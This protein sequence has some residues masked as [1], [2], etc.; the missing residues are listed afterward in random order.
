MASEG[1]YNGG[2]FER[3]LEVLGRIDWAALPDA[4]AGYLRSP[5]ERVR[6]R[7]AELLGARGDVPAMDLVARTMDERADDAL[8][9]GAL[10]GAA[11]A[12][13]LGRATAMFRAALFDRVARDL[14]DP[15]PRMLRYPVMCD[16]E[17]MLMT[18]DPRR[19]AEVLTR[20]PALSAEN[21]N[22]DRALFVIDEFRLPVEPAALRGL[23]PGLES[24]S[25]IRAVLSRLAAA[26]PSDAVEPLLREHLR[27]EDLD[28]R[29]DAFSL[30]LAARGINLFRL[31]LAQGL[32]A[33]LRRVRGLHQVLGVTSGDGALAALVEVPRRQ[34][35]GAIEL[36]RKAGAPEA[37]GAME[38]AR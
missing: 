36:L 25:A 38:R 7:V 8:T 35:K 26:G 5:R 14:L 6:E 2:R 17:R 34:W 30:L 3:V 12:V 16:A 9:R 28:V 13:K 1:G 24:A 20:P 10:E 27:H 29:S 15:G 31:T 19:G 37:A 33:T 32:N 23:L 18:L 4:M 22:L 11:R 21:P